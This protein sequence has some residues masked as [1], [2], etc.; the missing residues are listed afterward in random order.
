MESFNQLN[1]QLVNENVYAILPDKEG[2][3]LLGTLSALVSFNPEKRSFT[4]IDKEKD[5]TP[6]TSQR[7]TILFR[8]SRKRLWIGGEEGISVFQQEGIEIE[9][10]PILPESSVT[11]MFT[12]CIY[13]AANG[14]IWVGTREGFYS[15]NEKRRK[16]NDIQQ[17]TVYPIMWSTVFWKIPSGVS[18]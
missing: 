4:T 1:S 17:L 5:G 10:A 12:N 6:F 16:S 9:K 3:I 11:K 14:I 2:S 13:E 15:F 7:I 18:G 8:D